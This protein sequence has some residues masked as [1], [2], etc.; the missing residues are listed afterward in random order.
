[1]AR[2]PHPEPAEGLRTLNRQLRAAGFVHHEVK[3]MMQDKPVGLRGW[4]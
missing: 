2:L 1:M 3:H 4:E